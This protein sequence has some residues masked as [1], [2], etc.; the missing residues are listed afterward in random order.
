LN[1]EVELK[2]VIESSDVNAAELEDTVV[3]T[4]Y[5]VVVI[6]EASV[7]SSSSIHRVLCL[8]VNAVPFVSERFWIGFSCVSSKAKENTCGC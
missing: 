7:L 5:G 8:F 3:E 4:S 2:D 6:N 1:D